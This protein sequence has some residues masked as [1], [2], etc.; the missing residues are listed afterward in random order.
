MKISLN[1]QLENF[2]QQQIKSGNYENAD[3]LIEEALTLLIKRHQYDEWVREIGQKV[4]IA[5]AQLEKGE[6]IDGETAI[7]QL[8][9]ELKQS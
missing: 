6:G 5:V 8:R 4:D 2:I 3:S 7:K 1:P 9:E